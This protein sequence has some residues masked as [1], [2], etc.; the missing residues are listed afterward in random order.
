MLGI[1]ICETSATEGYTDYFGAKNY[2]ITA[3]TKGAPLQINLKSD[4]ETLIK[5]LKEYQQGE[6]DYLTFINHCATNGIEKWIVD[7]EKMICTCYDLQGNELLI[8][9]TPS[10]K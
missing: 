6:S 5:W 7:T 9:V 1:K 3:H 2:H 4:K 10:S 8:E